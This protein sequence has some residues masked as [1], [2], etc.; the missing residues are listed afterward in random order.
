VWNKLDTEREL[1][2]TNNGKPF[3]L[4]IPIDETN[5][6]DVLAS[7]RQANV[8]RSIARLQLAAAKAGL[9]QMTLEEA[10][11]KIATARALPVTS[12]KMK[13][14]AECGFTFGIYHHSNRI[15]H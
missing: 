9:D 15:W 11:T 8:M 6:D 10:N 7:V 14:L 2:V 5:L 13:T 12:Y 1:V 3:A 4:M